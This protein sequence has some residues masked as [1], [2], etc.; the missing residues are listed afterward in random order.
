MIPAAVCFLIF[1]KHCLCTGIKKDYVKW[2][3]MGKCSRSLLLICGARVTLPLSMHVDTS[4]ILPTLSSK[5]SKMFT[6]VA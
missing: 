3:G 4:N 1:E 2:G 6:G 5:Y